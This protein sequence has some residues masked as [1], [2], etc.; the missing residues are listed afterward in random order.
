MAFSKFLIK[1]DSKIKTVIGGEVD[2]TIRYIRDWTNGSTSNTG[3]HWV[4]L[5]AIDQDDVNQALGIAIT[6]NRTDAENT[7]YPYSRVTDGGTN[8]ANYAELSFA[9][10]VYVQVDL[11]TLMDIK[12][13]KVW[14]YY[15]DGRTYYDTKTEVSKDGANWI[16][17]FDSVESGTY[18]EISSGKTH[19]LSDEFFPVTDGVLTTV[20]ETIPSDWEDLK[21]LF[22]DY[23]SE[24]TPT[25]FKD[26]I[27]S[28]PVLLCYKDTNDIYQQISES[29][30]E[31]ALGI[32]PNDALLYQTNSFVIN[33]ISNVV[34][35]AV[36]P[37][38][39]IRVVFS[40]DEGST[41]YAY[42]TAAFDFVVVSFDITSI[43]VD[44]NTVSEINDSIVYTQWDDF[45]GYGGETPA[46]SIMFA[47]VLTSTASVQRLRINFREVL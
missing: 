21:Q 4:E 17:I 31:L 22:I 44:G 11:G 7:S 24:R 6:T 28:Q 32:T 26:C 15:S 37:L 35:D 40:K 3:D 18:A 20:T 1:D 34:I 8:T 38:N 13:V 27:D 14:H 2:R 5:Q 42:D 10:P 33:G 12:E 9:D 23:G 19:S 16:T 47:L 39:E 25:E 29:D 41:W 36:D 30:F 43:K 46:T 45:T